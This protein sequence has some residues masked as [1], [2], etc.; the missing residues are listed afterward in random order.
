M[1]M[2]K[3]G[4]EPVIENPLA[5]WTRRSA[6]LPKLTRK[7]NANLV[8]SE[9]FSFAKRSETP[10]SRY[11]ELRL[12]L[13]DYNSNFLFRRFIK[14][15]IARPAQFPTGVAAFQSYQ[16]EPFYARSFFEVMRDLMLHLYRLHRN[17]STIQWRIGRRWS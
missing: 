11:V 3:R 1:I 10:S 9:S 16:L 17:V 14:R 4:K 12:H 15:G 2:K 13:K 6:A 5:D 7:A 8:V